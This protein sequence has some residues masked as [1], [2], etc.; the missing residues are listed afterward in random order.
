M[1]LVIFDIDGTLTDTTSVDDS[2]YRQTLQETF[3]IVPDEKEWQ[4]IKIRTSGTDSG[5]TLQ[6][7]ENHFGGE[8]PENAYHTVKHKFLQILNFQRNNFPEKFTAVTGSRNF[9]ELLN[10]SENIIVGFATGS[11]KESG[12]LKLDS[13]GISAN[14][15]FYSN[16]DES[17]KRF[18]IIT[19]VLEKVKSK[20]GI[21]KFEKIIYFGDG[22]WDFRAAEILG[23]DFIGVDFH[24]TGRL[25]S[26][27]PAH[28]IKDFTE[29]ERIFNL[30]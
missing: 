25:N 27:N 16:S 17:D 10:Q 7:L 18:Q 20:R 26:L 21:K 30:I 2:S 3:S 15:I 5:I 22:E 9:V 19:N 4:E 1:K 12:W 13:I 11:W 6:L 24:G 23:I 14:D 28:I 8:F 29:T